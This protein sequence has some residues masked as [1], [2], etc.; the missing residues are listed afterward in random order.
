MRTFQQG[1]LAFLGTYVGY[2]VETDLMPSWVFQPQCC[3][4]DA[5]LAPALVR[6]LVEA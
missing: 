6:M 2:D 1:G 4:E 5:S 3:E